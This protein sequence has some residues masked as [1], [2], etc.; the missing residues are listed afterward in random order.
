MHLLNY[1]QVGLL[2]ICDHASS[3]PLKVK[4]PISLEN[5]TLFLF[6]PNLE[7]FFFISFHFI[8]FYLISFFV[9]SLLDVVHKVFAG[10]LM[11]ATI[12]SA[13]TL[14]WTYSSWSQHI[15]VLKANLVAKAALENEKNDSSQSQ[16]K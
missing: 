1:L 8:S 2:L 15:R 12:G 10:S 4:F 5:S 7:V 13:I 6:Y 3:I 11:L 16:M 9:M 14:G